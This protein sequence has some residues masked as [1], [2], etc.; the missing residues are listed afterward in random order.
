MK[1]YKVLILLLLSV[2]SCT[3]DDV[4]NSIDK[5]DLEGKWQINNSSEYVSIEFNKSNT[6]L[7]GKITDGEELVTY[8]PYQF[9]PNRL[10]LESG[11]ILSNFSVEEINIS[12]QLTTTA[13]DVAMLQGDLD[14][15]LIQESPLNDLLVRSWQT[16]YF[17]E[18]GITYDYNFSSLFFSTNGTYF[19]EDTFEESSANGAWQWFDTDSDIICIS[20]LPDFDCDNEFNHLVIESITEDSLFCYIPFENYY[21]T[22]SAID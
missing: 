9:E 11:E 10:I 17:I 21:L 7:I 15:N 2:G 14:E 1:I 3:S 18:D 16:A 5:A 6:C 19:F 12:F 8:H 22:Y 4:D 20:N 13:N